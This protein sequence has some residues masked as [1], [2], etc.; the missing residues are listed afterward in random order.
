MIHVFHRSSP[1]NGSTAS[2]KSAQPR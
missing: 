2:S 1:R